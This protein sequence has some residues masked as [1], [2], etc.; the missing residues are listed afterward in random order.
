MEQSGAFCAL[1]Y[2]IGRYVDDDAERKDPYLTEQRLMVTT[3]LD[4]YS[5]N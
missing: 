2:I 3:T 5:L 1:N 4:R